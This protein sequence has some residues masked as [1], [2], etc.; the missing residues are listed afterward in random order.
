MSAEYPINVL[1]ATLSVSPSGYHAWAQRA[2]SQR[3]V[4]NAA[5]LP[6]ITEAYRESRQTGS[7]FA[8]QTKKAANTPVVWS[9]LKYS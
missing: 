2:P 9:I 6:M 3:A 7:D 4:A 1:C 5:L 8:C